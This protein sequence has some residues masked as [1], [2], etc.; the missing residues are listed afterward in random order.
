[1]PLGD[2][3]V[4]RQELDG[5]VQAPLLLE[6]AHEARLLVEQACGA[7]GASTDSAWVWK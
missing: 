2:L 1:M 7:A 4:G 6:V 3:V 5:A